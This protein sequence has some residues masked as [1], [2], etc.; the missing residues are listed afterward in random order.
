MEIRGTRGSIRNTWCTDHTYVVDTVE[1][2]MEAGCARCNSE[3]TG[4]R[5]N[6]RKRKMVK[7]KCDALRN[8]IEKCFNDLFIDMLGIL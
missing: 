3:A 6:G 5:Q 2:N 8:Y 4:E 7:V 1:T